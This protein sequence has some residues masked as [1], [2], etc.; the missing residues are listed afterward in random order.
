M[1]NKIFKALN[2]CREKI[3]FNTVLKAYVLN[4]D[5][6]S[7]TCKRFVIYIRK[8][9]DLKMTLTMLIEK[10]EYITRNSNTA[11]YNKKN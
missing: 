9:R 4:L 1:K 5:N 10:Q 2:S 7:F 3:C 8:R 6:K 11:L